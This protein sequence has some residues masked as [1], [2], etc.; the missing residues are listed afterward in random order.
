MRSL[1][2][3]IFMKDVV[4]RWVLKSIADLM[5]REDDGGRAFQKERTDQPKQRHGVQRVHGMFRGYEYP[6]GARMWDILGSH[7][8]Q[9]V[10]IRWPRK[11]GPD[12]ADHQLQTKE[13][14]LRC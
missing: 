12:H 14:T 10:E 3:W 13:F 8:G 2:K 11:L 9:V 1:N 5:G 6:I 4:L 7:W